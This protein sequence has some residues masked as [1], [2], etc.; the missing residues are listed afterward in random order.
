MFNQQYAAEVAK[1]RAMLFLPVEG[2]F[3]LFQRVGRQLLMPSQ[4]EQSLLLLFGKGDRAHLI[5]C[6]ATPRSLSS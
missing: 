6:R 5:S 4:E 1:I 2:S 3:H